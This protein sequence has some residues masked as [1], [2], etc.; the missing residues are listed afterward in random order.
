M[1][2]RRK[3][4]KLFDEHNSGESFDTYLGQFLGI[5]E[6]LKLEEA[7]WSLSASGAI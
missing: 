4:S 3:R 5:Q 6:D 2:R 1:T 7:V